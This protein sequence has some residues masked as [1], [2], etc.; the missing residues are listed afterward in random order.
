MFTVVRRQYEH[1]NIEN[2]KTDIDLLLLEA[3]FQ[4]MLIT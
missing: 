3:I 1:Y 4:P 2:T